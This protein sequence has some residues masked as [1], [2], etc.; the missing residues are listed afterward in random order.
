M[1]EYVSQGLWGDYDSR[2]EAVGSLI[3]WF[4]IYFS[5]F[6]CGTYFYQP[7]NSQMCCPQWTIRLEVAKSRLTQK[8]RR[9]IRDVN[10]ELLIDWLNNFNKIL[11][12][13]AGE[14][15]GKSAKL[16]KPI[17]FEI[18]DELP[19][20]SAE[21]PETRTENLEKHKEKAK[22]KRKEKAIKR[23]IE[24]GLDVVRFFFQL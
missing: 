20:T 18:I 16:A 6:S 2:V 14:S 21:K 8:Q 12:F 5:N 1:P 7:Q 11:A 10:C 9:V 17:R 4:L 13:V 15:T 23:W 22:Y 24:K 19:S 3:D